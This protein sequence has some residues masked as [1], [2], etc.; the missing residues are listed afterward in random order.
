MN[1]LKTQNILYSCDNYRILLKSTKNLPKTKLPKTNPNPDP[2]L[3]PSS[4][5]NTES[6]PNPNSKPKP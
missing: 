3:N 2:N 1:D 6:N 4:N 5:T